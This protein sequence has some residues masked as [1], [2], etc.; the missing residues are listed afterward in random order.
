MHNLWMCEQYWASWSTHPLC[1]SERMWV[2]LNE[3]RCVG[4]P[5]MCWQFRHM[6]SNVYVGSLFFDT[7]QILLLILECYLWLLLRLPAVLMAVVILL[8]L[9]V[10]I[11]ISGRLF[12]NWKWNS[13]IN[14]SYFS[15]SKY[16]DWT[17][18]CLSLS[19]LPGHEQEDLF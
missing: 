2:G 15:I 9:A 4:V 13:F 12:W 17:T 11:L 10:G 14:C 16:F 7:V 8:F 1:V 19:T 5:G 6:F 3:V 18:L